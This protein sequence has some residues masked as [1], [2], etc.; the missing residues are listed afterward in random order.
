MNEDL[1]KRFAPVLFLHPKEKFFPVDAKRFVERANLWG[2]RM[3][4]DSKAMWGGLASD[5]FPRQPLVRSGEL[6]GAE[7]ESGTLVDDTSLAPK[8]VPY[9]TFL[10]LGGWKDTSR[11]PEPDV[12]E[13]STNVYADRDAIA[14]K[15]A[16]GDLYDSRFWYYAEFFDRDALD[17]VAAR[18]TAPDVKPMLN[19]NSALLCYYFFFPAHTQSVSSDSCNNITSQEAV[20]HAG[21]WQCVSILL[22]GDGTDTAAGYK[23]TFFGCS[24]SRPAVTD[25]STD[26]RPYQFDD[27]GLT[28]MKVERWQPDAG[29]AAGLPKLDDG[30]PRLFVALGTHSL[31]TAP[32]TFEVRPFPA[33][34]DSQWCG[35]YDA[36]SVA[37]PDLDQDPD[38][39]LGH[40][41]ADTAAF[42]AKVLAG[43]AF[44]GLFGMIAGAVLG[45]I[46]GTVPHGAGLGIR[47]TYDSPD[48]EQAPTASTAQVI[49]PEGVT[50]S[51]VTTSQVTAWNVRQGLVV[52]DRTYD[53]LVDRDKQ[54]WWPNYKTG[55]GFKGRWG[56][57]VT[58]DF[59][60]RRSGPKFPDYSKM[61]LLALAHGDSASLFDQ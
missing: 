40:S 10:E 36:P 24:G 41:F 12:T 19:K 20:C 15:Y 49:S 43:S 18:I 45:A 54:H 4:F 53:Y 31:F 61:F 46:E 51:G 44:G 39:T 50:V 30:H 60:P 35:V 25:A 57:Q 5:P 26:Y 23:P 13:S 48:P 55:G 59:L 9:E 21:D 28:V 29:S 37:P 38:D 7:G 34:R 27:D 16:S 47:G 6:A 52:R 3:P 58:S 17:V 22:K 32:G 33:D 14:S 1:V 8:D 56:Q 2:A 42:F 11:M